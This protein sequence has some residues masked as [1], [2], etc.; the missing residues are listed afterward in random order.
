MGKGELFSLF[1]NNSKGVQGVDG[2]DGSKLDEAIDK[3][4][5]EPQMI[6]GKFELHEFRT[7]ST[8]DFNDVNPQNGNNTRK[9]GM[10]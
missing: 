4:G 3:E 7:K 10:P 2:L 9:P 5:W 6:S 8:L 1:L